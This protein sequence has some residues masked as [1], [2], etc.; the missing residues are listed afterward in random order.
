[1]DLVVR[2]EWTRL[3]TNGSEAG[4]FVMC[5]VGGRVGVVQM[6]APFESSALQPLYAAGNLTCFVVHDS[7]SSVLNQTVALPLVRYGAPVPSTIKLQK[8]LFSRAYSGRQLRSIDSCRAGLRVVLAPGVGATATQIR[9]YRNSLRAD[10][11]SGDFKDKVRTAFFWAAT[12]ATNGTSANTTAATDRS[13]M[14]LAKLESVLNGSVACDWSKLAMSEQL[15]YLRVDGYCKVLPAAVGAQGG[16]ACLVTLL[17][18]LASESSVLYIEV[19]SEH[20]RLEARRH[21]QVG[22]CLRRG[23]PPC[24]VCEQ[25]FP[26][27]KTSNVIASAVAQSG[28][29]N[30]WP[31]YDAG[32]D[33]T[34]QVVQ[35][36]DTG[37]VSLAHTRWTPLSPLGITQDAQPQGNACL[38]GPVYLW[39]R[40]WSVLHDTVAAVQDMRSCW[41]NDTR[42]NVDPTTWDVAAFDPTR[43]KVIQYVAWNDAVDLPGGHGTHVSGALLP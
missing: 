36:A 21:A 35:V 14:W 42:G 15:P 27:V 8:G 9:A 3:L 12:A 19:R 6:T 24:V 1:L 4:T 41:F 32:I 25:E 29:A 22:G 34:G 38:H 23:A 31:V 20:G 2:F 11:L 33:G 18:F 7:A 17:A 13:V 10:L 39:T 30:R 16:S 5:A 37:V 28:V 43:R 26:I 40:W